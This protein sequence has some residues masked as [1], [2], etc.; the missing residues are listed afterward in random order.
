MDLCST[1]QM[2]I[3]ELEDAVKTL[4]KKAAPGPD[5]IRNKMLKYLGYGATEFFMGIS[6]LMWHPAKFPFR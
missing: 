3:S 4:K 5:G 6:N 2:T 1:E